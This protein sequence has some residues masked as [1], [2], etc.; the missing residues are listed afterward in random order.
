MGALVAVGQRV[1]VGVVEQRVVSVS[2]GKSL[3]GEERS[4]WH[5]GPVLRWETFEAHLGADA[6]VRVGHELRLPVGASLHL[7]VGVDHADGDAGDSQHG[8]EDLPGPRCGEEPGA[9]GAEL[10]NQS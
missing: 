4:V 7:H 8:G 1:G 3:E 6:Q 9:G 10:R 5:R 2:P